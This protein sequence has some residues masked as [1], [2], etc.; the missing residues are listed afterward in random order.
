MITHTVCSVTV[1]VCSNQS[2]L[3][4]PYWNNI[5]RC[6]TGASNQ[7]QTYSA[8]AQIG[9]GAH[10]EMKRLVNFADDALADHTRGLG[11]KDE[12]FAALT[13]K[14]I[15]AYTGGGFS[16]GNTNVGAEDALAAYA[17]FMVQRTTQQPPSNTI[18]KA[19]DDK[20]KSPP[21]PKKL[22]TTLIFHSHFNNRT[23]TST[24]DMLTSGN[25]MTHFL[26][27]GDNGKKLLIRLTQKIA[28]S[29]QI[30]SDTRR[31][32]RRLPDAFKQNLDGFFRR[33][34]ELLRHFFCLFQQLERYYQQQP[35]EQQE[36]S[37]SQEEKA[38]DQLK[39][40]LFQIVKRMEIIYRE[41]ELFR[42][43]CMQQQTNDNALL[44]ENERKIVLPIMKQLDNAV[45][46]HKESSW[47]G[48]VG[49]VVGGGFQPAV[50]S[51]RRPVQ[52]QLQQQQQQNSK[53]GV[54]T[55]SRIGNGFI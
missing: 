2:L 7:P 25:P 43:Q 33:S 44:V 34:S 17:R 52:R 53:N 40:K 38:L 4:Y 28:K 19:T 42:E 1:H 26:S 9:G 12:G 20:L 41:M 45:K 14:N 36:T 18:T 48:S 10:E 55:G 6:G 24:E 11:G 51:S 13:L 16:A 39:D 22:K 3:F 49:S 29:T 35:N 23:A 32:A 27:K 8:S 47:K 30:E 21:K 31:V 46:L 5:T 37:T 15:E 50:T 54:T